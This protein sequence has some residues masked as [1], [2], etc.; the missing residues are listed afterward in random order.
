MHGD[1]FIV[2]CGGYYGHFQQIYFDCQ[3]V[4][5]YSGNLEIFKPKIT[6]I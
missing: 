2:Y 4:V 1:L 5:G 6:E 3:G